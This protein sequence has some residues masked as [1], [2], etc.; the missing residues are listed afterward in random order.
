MGPGSQSFASADRHVVPC[1]ETCQMQLLTSCSS[2]KGSE[3]ESAHVTL[4]QMTNMS[5]EQR[6]VRKS[7]LTG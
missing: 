1:E 7:I 3:S 4:V 2:G 5:F 6:G